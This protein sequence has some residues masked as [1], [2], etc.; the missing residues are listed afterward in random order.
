MHKSKGGNC[1]TRTRTK[2]T[3]RFKF[4]VSRN[5]TSHKSGANTVTI[6][7]SNIDSKG[8]NTQ[9]GSFSSGDYLT[10]T[11]KEAKALQKFLNDTLTS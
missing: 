9:I 10:M 4:T 11:V 2:S 3:K 8:Y 1:M 5:T 6:T 7:A